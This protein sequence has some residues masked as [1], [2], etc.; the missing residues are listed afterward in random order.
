MV[1]LLGPG[2]FG[3]AR[4]AMSRPLLTPGNA[5]ADPDTWA[6]DCSSPAAN[7]G[8]ENRA[9][10]FNMLLAQLRGVIR[11][12]GIVENNNDDL[13]LA[14][15][16]RSHWMNFRQA[17]GTA[18]ALTIT[19]DP[20]PASWSELINVPLFVRFTAMNT[21]LATLAVAGL[22][23]AQ[24]IRLLG[25]TSPAPAGALLPGSVGILVFDGFSMELLNGY[26]P[27][28]T[29]F[30]IHQGAGHDGNPGTLAQ[31]IKSIQEA[32]RRTVSGGVT[33]ISLVSDYGHDQITGLRGRRVVIQGRDNSG[34]ALFNRTIYFEPNPIAAHLQD[35]ATRDTVNYP[36]NTS[37]FVLNAGSSWQSNS[38]VYNRGIVSG[39]TQ[40]NS[41]QFIADG[42]ASIDL[43]GG[44]LQSP[45]SGVNTV[46]FASL[47]NRLSI[48]F[49]GVAVDG[50]TSG[51][52]YTNQL[53]GTPLA[54]GVN[55]N[56]VW[57]FSSNVTSS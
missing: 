7:D 22:P 47:L 26:L 49:G 31:P 8:T 34:T 29:Q 25:S 27:T 48:S 54:P 18:T 14:R 35:P 12:T 42:Q 51:K 37:A 10:L 11:R 33:Y 40:V 43:V 3:A 36:N 52:I 2:A 5:P 15:A 56:S 57:N 6:Q 9:G 55:P 20:A 32:L 4:A 19:L 45:P 21:D 46:W 17:A 53:G 39:G 38:I 16:I 44:V 30:V 23:G 28:T 24:T 50:D 13:M 41:A 1:D